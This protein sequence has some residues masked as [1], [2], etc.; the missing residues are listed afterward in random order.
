MSVDAVRADINA[1]IQR[2]RLE[3]CA[4]TMRSALLFWKQYLAETQPY[5]LSLQDKQDYASE[6]KRIDW[7]LSEIFPDEEEVSDEADVGG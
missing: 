7:L 2:I 5:G 1:A 6:H 4:F 3:G